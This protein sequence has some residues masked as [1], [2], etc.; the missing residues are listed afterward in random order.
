MKE[1]FTS[2]DKYIVELLPIYNSNHEN[3]MAILATA[4][5]IDMVLK[6]RK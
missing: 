2:A 5:T 4:I 3:K 6:E 1:V